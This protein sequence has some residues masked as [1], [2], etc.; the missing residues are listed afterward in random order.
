MVR[1]AISV[2]GEDYVKIYD[3]AFEE[4]WVDV[5]PNKGKKSGAYSGGSYHTNPFLL[6]NYQDK[7]DS[8]STLAHE[9]GH[10]IHSYL[11]RNNNPYQYGDYPIIVAEVASTVNELLLAKYVLKNS[12]DIEE[13]KYILERMLELF[14]ATI[15]RQTM[16][17][18]M[19]K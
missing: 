9:I 19:K 5:Y 7:Y 10:S 3:K 16:F 14:R 11:T 6:L 13:K 2:L 15:F 17:A 18:E 8:V 12:K 1:N 4:K